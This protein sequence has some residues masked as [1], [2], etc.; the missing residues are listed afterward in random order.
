MIATGQ[1]AGL[2]AL[3][4][5]GSRQHRC[6]RCRGRAS[7][8]AF[9]RTTG[10]Y[11]TM[12]SIPGH[13]AGRWPADTDSGTLAGRAALIYGQM[14]P[15]V[16]VC[17]L[18]ARSAG[19]P[20]GLTVTPGQCATSAHLRTGRLTR[21]PNRPSKQRVRWQDPETRWQQRQAAATCGHRA[22]T[23][24]RSS[25]PFRLRSSR[26]SWLRWSDHGCPCWRRT[27]GIKHHL[28]RRPTAMNSS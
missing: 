16:S 12:T 19:Q 10:R 15:E 9:S 7:L 8:T 11:Q 18:C 27:F 5:Q 4:A 3:R 13:P 23:A 21:C 20:R 26:T 1:Q 24:S 22:P 28:C 25:T 17:P 14:L 2:L 6:G